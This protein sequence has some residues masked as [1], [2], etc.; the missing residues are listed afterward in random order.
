MISFELHLCLCSCE[1]YCS[2]LGGKLNCKIM[3]AFLMFTV[4]IILEL[5][6]VV[7][8]NSVILT[9]LSRGFSL[10]LALFLLD[11]CSGSPLSWP[12]FF[13]LSFHLP[14]LSRQ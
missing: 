5:L 7:L 13:L 2:Y 14:L 8:E 4:F 6:N 3:P 10:D 1:A 9:D 12:L 11:G